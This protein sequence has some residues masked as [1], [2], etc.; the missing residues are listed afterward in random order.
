[1]YDGMA[2]KNPNWAYNIHEICLGQTVTIK[3]N[4]HAI[5]FRTKAKPDKTINFNS[6]LLSV[7]FVSKTQFISTPMKPKLWRDEWAISLP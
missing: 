1:M 5:N 7:Y 2:E 6:Y 4:I 3:F